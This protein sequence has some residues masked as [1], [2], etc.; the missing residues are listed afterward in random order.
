MVLIVLF[1]GR[2]VGNIHQ[3]RFKGG[4]APHTKSPLCPL[5]NRLELV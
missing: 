4:F 2:A 1:V 5:R 3:R